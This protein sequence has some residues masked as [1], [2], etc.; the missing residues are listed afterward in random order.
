MEVEIIGIGHGGVALIRRWSLYIEK[1][2]G[3]VGTNGGI[4][5]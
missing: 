2:I 3:T 1:L 4:S 5:I